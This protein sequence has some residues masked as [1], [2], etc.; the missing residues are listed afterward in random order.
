MTVCSTFGSTPSAPGAWAGASVLTRAIREG[1]Q[2]M[3]SLQIKAREKRVDPHVEMMLD[4]W[5]QCEGSGHWRLDRA[6]MLQAMENGLDINEFR[7]FLDSH[8]TQPL[9]EPVEALLQSCRDQA[10]ALR[11]QEP[12]F[13]YRCRDEATCGAIAGHPAMRGLCQLLGAQNLVVATQ[14][15]ARFRETLRAIGFGLDLQD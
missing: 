7:D 15:D 2:V 10:D 1:L 4:T 12:A 5:A 14:D 11:P 9:P 6:R 3:P 13:I 8:D